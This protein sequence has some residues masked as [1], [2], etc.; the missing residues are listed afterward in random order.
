MLKKHLMHAVILNPVTFTAYPFTCLMIGLLI[1]TFC[2][3]ILS[4][5]FVDFILNLFLLSERIRA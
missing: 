1:F 3:H 2:S 4:E 5:A